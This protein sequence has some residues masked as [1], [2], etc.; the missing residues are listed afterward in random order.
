MNPVPRDPVSPDA[1]PVI[2]GEVLFDV[3]PDGASVLG[4]APFNVA[5]HLQG[6]GV[7]PLF[8]SRVG[9]DARGEEVLAA[10][11]DWGM[12][13]GGVQRDPA[14]PT[15]Q[16]RVSIT[17]G[18]PSFDI[19]PDQAYDH[20]QADTARALVEGM[21]VPLLYHGTLIARSEPSR[22][23]LSAL[24]DLLALPTLVD[25]NLRAPWWHRST[26]SEALFNARWG[27]LNDLELGEV[28][29]SEDLPEADLEAMARSL[30]ARHG[31]DLLVVTE[32]SKGAM[33]VS[34]D[35]VLRDAPPPVEKLVDTV[36]AGDAFSA[37]L[38]LG[39]LRGWPL[40]VVL[41]RA[42]GFAARICQVRGA[43]TSERALYA[44]LS[45]AWS[46]EDAGR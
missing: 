28:S 1:R 40:P 20:I 11:A 14:H 29:R 35:E 27:K 45:E 36:G 15:G 7:R 34:A 22:A 25:I 6:F 13:A 32:G 39:L 18:Q 21:Q 3:F 44:D 12:D 43:T 41:R 23:A 38:V 10:M 4:G 2:L 33:L 42:L 9:D 26:V 30:R 46:R 8:V 17:D 19:V 16:V 24:R 37:V 5:W 31:L